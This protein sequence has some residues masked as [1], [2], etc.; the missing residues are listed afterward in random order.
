MTNRKKD[1]VIKIPPT[2]K[3]ISKLLIFISSAM[4]VKNVKQVLDFSYTCVGV[5]IC[6]K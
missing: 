3:L 4:A 1:E 2:K 5:K 6:V